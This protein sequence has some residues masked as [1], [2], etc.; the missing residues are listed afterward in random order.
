MIG[1]VGYAAPV[2]YFQ[3]GATLGDPF[4]QFHLGCMYVNGLGVP[5]DKEQ[6]LMY[7]SQAD[8]KLDGVDLI[9]TRLR[10]GELDE[11]PWKS[12]EDYRRETDTIFSAAGAFG[13]HEIE[14]KSVSSEQQYGRPY[15]DT[16]TASGWREQG[17]RNLEHA[18]QVAKSAEQR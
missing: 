1:R 15:F 13:N 9:Y 2:Q 11:C 3:R 6:G 10:S 14:Q 18:G 12:A 7:L 5:K 17:L 8:G 4:A 16:P